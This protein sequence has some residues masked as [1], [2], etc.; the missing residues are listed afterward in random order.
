[1]NKLRIGAIY[2]KDGLTP[3]ESHQYRVGRDGVID[4]LNIGTP[5]LFRY[6][7]GHGTLITSIINDIDEDCDGVWVYTENSVYRLDT[8]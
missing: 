6:A 4:N 3:K 7:D 8:I 1:M 2:E 5:M